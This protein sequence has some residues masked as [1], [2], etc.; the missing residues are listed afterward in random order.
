MAVP[1]KRKSRSKRDSRRAT[2]Q[3]SAR[4]FN[5]CDKCNAP[6]LAHHACPACGWYK[7]RTAVESE[8][9]KA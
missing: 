8:E 7:D 3:I 9:I 1:K 5:T 4:P 2:H 6:K